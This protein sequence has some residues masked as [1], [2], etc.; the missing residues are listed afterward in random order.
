MH[1]ADRQILH[2][3]WNPS[4]QPFGRATANNSEAKENV[5]R[6]SEWFSRVA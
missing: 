1:S 4:G 5:V 2:Q 3:T 6:G